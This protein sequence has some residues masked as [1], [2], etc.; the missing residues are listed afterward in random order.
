MREHVAE[1]HRAWPSARF[2]HGNQRG[3]E[4]PFV[5]TQVTG[6]DGIHWR[7]QGRDPFRSES[8]AP[9]FGEGISLGCLLP[10]PWWG[11]TMEVANDVD[12]TDAW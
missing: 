7:R 1:L 3:E 5:V 9:C 11:A 12:D 8:P 10:F 6:I 4:D 2:G